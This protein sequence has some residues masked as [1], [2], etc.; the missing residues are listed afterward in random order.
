MQ[1]KGKARA[2]EM[3]FACVYNALSLIQ[4]VRTNVHSYD[5]IGDDGKKNVTCRGIIPVP[6]DDDV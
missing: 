2:I 1:S 6:I 4:H 5:N 3:H